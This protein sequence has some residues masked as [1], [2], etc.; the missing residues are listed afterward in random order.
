MPSQIGLIGV[1][2]MGENLA[3]NMAGKGFAV[4]SSMP[5][6]TKVEQ[7]VSGRGHGKVSRAVI[8]CR[9]WSH[10]WSVREKSC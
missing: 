4:R 6:P 2:V 9:S 7:F 5:R 3:L 10:R 1:G 8:R